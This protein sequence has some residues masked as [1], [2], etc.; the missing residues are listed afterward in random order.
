[1]IEQR[2][3]A[4]SRRADVAAVRLPWSVCAAA[5]GDWLIFLDLARNRYRAI[6]LVTAPKILNVGNNEGDFVVDDVHREALVREGLIASPSRQRQF[7]AGAGY[8]RPS[9]RDFIVTMDAALW[10]RRI[11]KHGALLEAFSRL[12]EAKARV[13][14]IAPNP[15]TAT[16]IHA[17]FASARIWIPAAY[18]CLFDSLSLMRFLLANGVCADLVFGVRGRPFAA[19]CWV[20]ACGEILDDGGEECRS[21]VE[22]VRV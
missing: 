16:L 10:A 11:V 2:T 6:K 4:R 19:H 3:S 14:G 22:I 9:W 5:D 8:N 7:K 20:E 12:S 1:M 18:V 17:R 15:E 21:F 13:R